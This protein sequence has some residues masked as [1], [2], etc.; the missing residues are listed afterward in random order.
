MDGT[1]ATQAERTLDEVSRLRN[2]TQV[3]AHSGA[4]FPAALIATLILLSI[5]L[6]EH[7][8][9]QP[10]E[11]VAAYPFWAGLADA[12]RSPVASYLFWFAGTPAIDAFG[13][14]PAFSWPGL[15][16][17]LLPVAA[18]VIVLGWAERSKALAAAGVWIALL[19]AWLCGSF[20]LG[21]LPGWLTW[22]LDGGEG[23]ALG[24][25]LSLRPGHY[26]IVMALPLL[27]FA[28]VRAW[29]ARRLR[30]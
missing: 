7:P 13:I 28:A 22:L 14:P 25:N 20:P 5:A 30:A 10:N 21:R 3:R 9:G 29:R 23:P 15:L 8:F 19:A 1:G 4:W 11:I 18:A 2:R 6:Y 16:T 24:G 26:L 27:M 17:P 12:Q